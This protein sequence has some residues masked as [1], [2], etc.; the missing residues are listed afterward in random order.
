MSILLGT[1]LVFSSMFLIMIV[2]VQRGRGGGLTGALGGAGGQSA[3]GAK[4]GDVFTRITIGAAAVW[5]ILC[6]LTVKF[7]GSGS[8][9]LDL[10]GV[11]TP[12]AGEVESGFKPEDKA[13]GAGAGKTTGI[14]EKI[15]GTEKP[16]SET[17]AT[18]TPETKTPATET[19]ATKTPATETPATETPA[20]PAAPAAEKKA[21]E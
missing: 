12:A 21:E 15:I 20:E 10:G 13:G 3:F 18:K 2:L 6:V 5:I 19:P 11:N 9:P 17:P 4:A 8:D 16:A 7:V 14:G 1:L